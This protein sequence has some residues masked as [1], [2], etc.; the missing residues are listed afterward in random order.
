MTVLHATEAASVYL[1]AY[2]RVDG[3][4]VD[5]V[6][7]ALF[8]TRSLVKQL[9]MRRTLFVFPVDL[10]GAAW[11]SAARRV[12]ESEARRVAKLIG[13]SGVAD[14]GTAWL[15]RACDAV[16]AHLAQSGPLTAQQVREQVPEVAAKVFVTPDKS[17]GRLTPVTPW[18]L[19]VL[20]LRGRIVRCENAGHWRVSRPRWT[21]TQE[22]LGDVPATTPEA[23][24]YAEL[25]RRWLRTFGPGTAAD[26][27]WWLGSTKAAATAALHD[28]GAVP[29]SLDSGQT[30]WLLPDDVEPEPDA[31][32]PWAA[33]LPVLDPT[34]MGW[35]QR[36]FYLAP[37]HTA[38]V[39]DAGGNGGATAWVDGRIVG[40]WAQDD[41][42]VVQVVL[43]EE[44]GGHG[45]AALGVEADRL[46]DWLGGVRI[47]SG[48]RPASMAP[49]WSGRK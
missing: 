7:R 4:T 9:A 15:E 44:V 6:D 11:G 13:D 32:E 1:A 21:L 16:V 18:V 10:L 39:F 26:V 43:H 33:L 47:T 40:S 25:V 31:V 3:L 28:V 8:R 49:G 19:N 27:Q 12:Q 37:E 20:A 48:V 36:D 30:G 17:Y 2:A 46:T 22:W 34:T 41:D 14:D 23:E 24:G 35:K 5:D 45:R 29:V 42:G 38:Y